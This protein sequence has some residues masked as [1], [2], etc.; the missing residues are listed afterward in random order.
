M[1]GPDEVLD[2]VREWVTKA[3]N[4]LLTAAHTIK[5][6]EH[7]PTD[8]VCYHAQQCVEKYLKAIL[9]L[10]GVDFPKSHDLERLA[11]F[12]PPDARARFSAE[13]QARL[14]EYA[15]SARY[16][17]WDEIPLAEARRAVALARRLRREMRRRLPRKVL[18]RRRSAPKQ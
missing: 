2:V 10:A 5:L 15:T 12:V 7:C 1:S 6:G 18:I 14:T 16:P 9:V 17:G 8:T 4:D 3:D 13:E 11:V